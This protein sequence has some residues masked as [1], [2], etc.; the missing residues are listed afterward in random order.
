[1]IG[2]DSG[3]LDEET[4]ILLSLLP[5]S[6]LNFGFNNIL[7][8]EKGK[9]GLTYE[10]ANEK[11]DNYRYT[12]CLCMLL[13]D[14]LL[15][16]SLSL[17][18]DNIIPC[19]NEVRK[20][21]LY[22]FFPSYWR[23]SSHSVTSMP[24]PSPTLLGPNFEEIPSALVE[25][26]S[27]K[28]CLKISNI[29]KLFG[30]KR[31][32]DHLSMT[33]YEGQ[34]F[35]LLGHNGAGKTTTLDVLTGSL[36]ETE[37]EAWAYDTNVLE[38]KSK[39]RRILGICPQHDILLSG[40]T[41][42]EHLEMF[43]ILKGLSRPRAKEAGEQ[44]LRDLELEYAKE[45]EVEKL[46]G[47]ERRKLCICQAFIGNSL[48]IM[49]DEP[50]S[51]MDT[52]GR[53]LIWN[54]LK[55]Y[56]RGRVIILTT[57]HM[58]EADYL[59]DRIAIMSEG[60]LKCLGAPLFLKN[61]FGGGYS[62]SCLKLPGALHSKIGEFV[63]NKIGG[64]KTLSDTQ[65]AITFQLPFEEEANFEALF[66]GLDARRAHLGIE[67]YGIAITSLEEVFIKI[68]KLREG[69][70]IADNIKE[71]NPY[72]LNLNTTRRSLLVNEPED[73]IVSM[74]MRTPRDI[75][76]NY[77]ISTEIISGMCRVFFLHLGA[78]ISKRI[79]HT[80]RNIGTLLIEVFVPIILVGGV[81]SFGLLE[82]AEEG[83]P[84]R[85]WRVSDYPT[86]QTLLYNTDGGNFSTQ[87][88]QKFI[89]TLPGDLVSEGISVLPGRA[90]R[91]L[92][93]ES[94]TEAPEHLSN[95][96][97]D[98]YTYI[99]NHWNSFH[100]AIQ[101]KSSTRDPSAYCALYVDKLNLTS[102]EL[103]AFLFTNITSHDSTPAF[104][105]FIGET[106]IRAVTGNVNL[107]IRVASHPLP[108]TYETINKNRGD[109]VFILTM[110]LTVAFTLIPASIITYI[111]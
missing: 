96:I 31:A 55:T 28:E 110:L 88:L 76:T 73:Y 63:R 34:I 79:I 83:S 11:I 33:M 60:K 66:N 21:P 40:L 50:T 53:R 2:N 69:E 36:R 71:N 109:P 65:G 92:E 57:H 93:D 8:M 85:W 25:Q 87:D 30:E 7:E 103:E 45:R 3:S 77:T 12:Y 42:R 82:Q 10:N 18:F 84:V 80:Y 24:P 98:P 48:V 101:S 26:E 4:K 16:G 23:G 86:P 1:M 52:S 59:G 49:L 51:G 29:S 56:K 78:L 64:C 94:D 13:A 111:V 108:P 35:A 91:V 75:F 38:E 19:E 41:T 22:I 62:L 6:A 27:R 32:V 58:D 15:Y 70:D 14:F 90:E 37:G 74:N 72:N 105:N 97:E 99:Y 100:S 44:L 9:I 68:G 61:R 46:S 20:S 17:Y 95:P 89:N 67:S 5:T 54:I 107:Q 39:F 43:G 102:G 106:F 47:G 81:L 104:S